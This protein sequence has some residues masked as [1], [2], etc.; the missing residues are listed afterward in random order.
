MNNQSSVVDQMNHDITFWNCKFKQ[1]F[2]MQRF[3]RRKRSTRRN[4]N[5]KVDAASETSLVANRKIALH[6]AIALNYR[7]EVASTAILR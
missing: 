5:S 7:S 4:F 3:S 2:H 6:Q 1:H